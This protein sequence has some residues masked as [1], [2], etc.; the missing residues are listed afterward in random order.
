MRCTECSHQLPVSFKGVQFCDTVCESAFRV[1]QYPGL[2]ENYKELA[3]RVDR[4]QNACHLVWNECEDLGDTTVEE[5]AQSCIDA[6]TEGLGEDA[7]V[8]NTINST[9]RMAL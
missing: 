5:L 9:I 3:A 2:L 1:R 6:V 4:L 7:N 8:E